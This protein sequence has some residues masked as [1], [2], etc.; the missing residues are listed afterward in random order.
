MLESAPL[1]PDA[2][3]ERL[4][5]DFENEPEFTKLKV[6]FVAS[7]ATKRQTFEKHFALGE[8]RELGGIAHQ[9]KGSA[10]CYGIRELSLV[11][12][13]LEDACVDNNMSLASQC[14]RELSTVFERS[15]SWKPKTPTA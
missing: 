12:G 11:A 6:D 7:L 15:M 4:Y 13:K 1:F 10:A 8:I 5:E 9:L 3:E 14:M 2:E